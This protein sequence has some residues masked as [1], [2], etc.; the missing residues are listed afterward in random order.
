MLDPAATETVVVPE[1][2]VPPTLQRRSLEESEV[3]GELL[4]TGRMFW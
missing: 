2:E 3:T 4:G 1:P